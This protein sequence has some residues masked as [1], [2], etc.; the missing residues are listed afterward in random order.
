[1]L[2][3]K[4]ESGAAKRKRKRQEQQ[5]RQSQQGALDKFFSISSSAMPEHDENPIDAPENQEER[6][7]ENL[8][9]SSKL[10]NL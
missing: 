8:Q 4:H 9:T 2:P 1:M 7:T 10:R 6:R 5:F 3:K